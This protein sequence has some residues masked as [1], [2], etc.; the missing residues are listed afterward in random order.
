VNL[1][2]DAPSALKP[3]RETVRLSLR[4]REI[5]TL[6][7]GI[8]RARKQWRDLDASRNVWVESG[9]KEQPQKPK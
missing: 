7:L 8:I 4:P 6:K 5:A 9:K 1:L 3:E 2:G